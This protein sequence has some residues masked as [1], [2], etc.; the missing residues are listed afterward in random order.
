MHIG[1][2]NMSQDGFKSVIIHPMGLGWRMD[3]LLTQST[4][5]PLAKKAMGGEGSERNKQ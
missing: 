3:I 4:E 5:V 1:K 2:E